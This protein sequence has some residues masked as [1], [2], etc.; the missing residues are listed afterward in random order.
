MVCHT[1]R[2]TEY[3]TKLLFLHT[4]KLNIDKLTLIPLERGNRRKEAANKNEIQR[5]KEKVKIST[6]KK[7]DNKPI[8]S[9]SNHAYR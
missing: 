6:T 5:E 2:I 3:V 1:H 4:T 7:V 9:V 8:S